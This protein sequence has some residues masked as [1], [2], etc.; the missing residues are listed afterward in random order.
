VLRGDGKKNLL[1]VLNLFSSPMSGKFEFRDPE[2]DRWVDC[3]EQELPGVSGIV[4]KGKK[5]VY[6]TWGKP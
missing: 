5:I 6:K 2:T 1:F 4:L 3:G